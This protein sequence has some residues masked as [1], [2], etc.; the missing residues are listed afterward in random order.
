DAAEGDPQRAD[1]CGAVDGVPAGRVRPGG[2]AVGGG[3]GQVPAGEAG[4][5]ELTLIRPLR[6]HLLPRVGEGMKKGPA[7][8]GP[9]AF[10]VPLL[11]P[12]DG[13]GRCGGWSPATTP[14]GS[15]SRSPPGAPRGRTRAAGRH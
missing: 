15:A 10:R 3:G 11:S 8:A 4:G 5:L 6:G 9:F 14:A 12:S 1:Q 13:T 2:A 7:I